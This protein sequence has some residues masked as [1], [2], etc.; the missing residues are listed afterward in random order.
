M[1][2]LGASCVIMEV[3]R[4]HVPCCQ[5]SSRESLMT[6]L[7]NT[8]MQRFP[9]G[10]LWGPGLSC[11]V[12]RKSRLHKRKPKVVLVFKVLHG[13]ASPYLAEN[14]QL[15]ALLTATSCDCQHMLDQPDKI[16]FWRSFLCCCRSETLEQSASMSAT[17]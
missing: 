6:K 4:K 15:I 13:S 9:V 5:S 3:I 17:A 16:M 7:T 2:T 10:D 12:S 1:K 14:C 8:V 11:S